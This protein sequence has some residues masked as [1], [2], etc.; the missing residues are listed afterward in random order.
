MSREY[1][2]CREGGVQRAGIA[3]MCQAVCR[4]KSLKCSGQ[5]RGVRRQA[6]IDRN[7]NDV[8]ARAPVFRLRTSSPPGLSS[9]LHS[10]HSLI[11]TS[12]V[13][14]LSFHFSGPPSNTTYD[15]RIK[16][17]HQKPTACPPAP[18]SP[19]STSIWPNG[20]S[21]SWRR[22]RPTPSATSLVSSS[23]SHSQLT[24]VP[25]GLLASGASASSTEFSETS[26]VSLEWR[27]TG[28][29]QMY[30]T[31]KGSAKR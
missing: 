10:T 7:V 28:L 1:G 6:Q 27:L 26:T 19:S 24:S 29:R 5:A 23:S 3:K 11:H 15:V 9:T 21:A 8:F 20:L 14:V 31:S 22:A 2:D 17:L 13:F 18:S 30:E 25:P 16:F 12:V 4:V